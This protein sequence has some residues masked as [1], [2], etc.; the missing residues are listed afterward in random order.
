MLLTGITAGA[1]YDL[2]E[3]AK[4]ALSP[5]DI[6]KTAAVGSYLDFIAQHSFAIMPQAKAGIGAEVL[7]LSNRATGEIMQFDVIPEDFNALECDI[8][9]NQTQPVFYQAGEDGAV[10]MFYSKDRINT[11]YQRWQVNEDAKQKRG[12][13]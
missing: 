11:L 1:Q 7:P 4:K 9:L 6:E 5:G 13:K 10:L 2:S 3:E 12:E 8:Q